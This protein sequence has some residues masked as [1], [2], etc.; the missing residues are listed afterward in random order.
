MEKNDKQGSIK[1]SYRSDD[2]NQVRVFLNCIKTS[3]E[4]WHWRFQ[5]W[6]QMHDGRLHVIILCRR[7]VIQ[8]LALKMK[9]E[10]QSH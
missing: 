3:G 9:V 6:W 7:W 10:Y 2:E 5:S 8:P 1:L 4:S